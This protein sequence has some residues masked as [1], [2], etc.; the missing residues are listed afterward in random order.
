MLSIVKLH[1]KQYLCIFVVKI[2][3][4]CVMQIPY[5]AKKQEINWLVK[6]VYLSRLCTDRLNFLHNFKKKDVFRKCEIK[7]RGQLYFSCIKK[8]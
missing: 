8:L 1:T 4:A 3:S 6:K 2:H 7:D 5:I